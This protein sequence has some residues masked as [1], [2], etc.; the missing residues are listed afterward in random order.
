MSRPLSLPIS[1]LYEPF[2]L[3]RVADCNQ[4]VRICGVNAVGIRI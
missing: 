1:Q 3:R 4:H 2:F